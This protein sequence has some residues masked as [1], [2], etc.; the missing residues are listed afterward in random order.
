MVD[1][2]AICDTCETVFPSGIVVNNVTNLVMSGNKAGPCPKC[3]NWG[4]IPD[5]SFSVMEGVIE[6]LNAPQR[7]IE[8]LKRFSEILHDYKTNKITPEKMEHRVEKEVPGVSTILNLLPKTR[9][10]KRSDLKFFI[11]TVIA[12]IGIVIAMQGN[13]EDKEKIETEQ[14]INNVYKME[15]HNY[16]KIENYIDEEKV[17]KTIRVEK[18]GRNEPCYCGSGL[19]YKKC[20][21]N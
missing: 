17:S 5:G 19:K 2:P 11:T 9:E 21:G 1:I 20:H 13:G 15:Q 4:H 14:I 16:Y 8:E 6:I 10:E 12:I 7:T 3:G 18:I